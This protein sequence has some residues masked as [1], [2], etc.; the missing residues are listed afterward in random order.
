MNINLFKLR[1][2]FFNTLYTNSLNKNNECINEWEFFEYKK[3]I[4]EN[5]NCI[6]GKNIDN[7]FIIKNINNDIKLI[8]GKDCIKKFMIDNKI[9]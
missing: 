3:S 2:N 6:C 8:I 1:N 4:I 7:L 5:N 9:L